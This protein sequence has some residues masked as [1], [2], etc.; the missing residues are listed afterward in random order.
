MVGRGEGKGCQEGMRVRDGGKGV[1][2]RMCWRGLLTCGYAQM[3]RASPDARKPAR[4]PSALDRLVS[5]THTSGRRVKFMGSGLGSS[6]AAAP[7]PMAVRA[8]ARDG[9][10][11]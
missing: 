7:R 10:K 4:R 2:G 11:G 6:S 1:L 5:P 8:F 3:S 9:R